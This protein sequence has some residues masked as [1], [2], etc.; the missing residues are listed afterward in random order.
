MTPKEKAK[1]IFKN[2]YYVDDPMGNYP[3]C[4]ETAKKCALFSA[5]EVLNVLFQHHEIDYWKDVVYELE[6]FTLHNQADA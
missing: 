1:E 3:M 5:R 2:M 6:V 4:F